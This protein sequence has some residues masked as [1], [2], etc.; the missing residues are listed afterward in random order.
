MI[1]RKIVRTTKEAKTEARD[2]I[3]QEKVVTKISFCGIPV[4]YEYSDYEAVDIIEEK[5]T[6]GKK[7]GFKS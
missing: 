5:K 7:I 2:Y 6:S 1:S 3:W 4:F